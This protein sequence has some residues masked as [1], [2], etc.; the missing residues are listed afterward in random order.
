MKKIVFGDVL[1]LINF[2]QLSTGEWCG[3]NSN[4]EWVT[5]DSFPKGQKPERFKYEAYAK[6]TAAQ[7]AEYMAKAGEM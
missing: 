5:I 2:H 6:A 1:S 4:G 7:S 3:H